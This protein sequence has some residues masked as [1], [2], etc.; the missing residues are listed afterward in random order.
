[1]ELIV[2]IRK[3]GCTWL[4]E[5]SPGLE[6]WYALFHR[7]AST[8]DDHGKREFEIKIHPNCIA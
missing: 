4:A 7:L 2:L 6:M 5:C 3:A 1:M 8:F